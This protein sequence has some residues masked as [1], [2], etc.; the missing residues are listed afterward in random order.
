MDNMICMVAKAKNSHKHQLKFNKCKCAGA[1]Q[2]VSRLFYTLWGTHASQKWLKLTV[3]VYFAVQCSIIPIICKTGVVLV[4]SENDSANQQILCLAHLDL[5]W[6]TWTCSSTQQ[7]LH[8]PVM[9]TTH[10][11]WCHGNSARS[12]ESLCICLHTLVMDTTCQWHC[13][14]YAEKVKLCE[15]LGLDRPRA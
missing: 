2:L 5:N 3:Q 14:S 13:G 10:Q 4:H 6:C 8:R 7:C 12:L 11:C 15:G 1:V 9:H